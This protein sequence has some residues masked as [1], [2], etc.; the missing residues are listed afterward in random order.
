MAL[1]LL[2]PL[3]FAAL[4]LAVESEGYRDRFLRAAVAFGVAAWALV[5]LLSLPSAVTR[6]ALAV[7]WLLVAV[8]AFLRRRPINLPRLKPDP[9]VVVC[10]AGCVTV[11]V[12]TGLL[13]VL[14]PPNSTDAMAYHLPRVVY[15][16]EQSSVR[17]FPTP[18]LNQIMLQPMAEY[19][20]LHAYLLAGGDWFLNLVQWSSSIGAMVGVSLVARELGA[21]ARGQALAALVS[22]TI[23]AGILASS[24]AKNDYVLA[25]WL[26]AAV[27]FAARVGAARWKWDAVCL[28]CAFGLAL[29]TKATAYLFMPALVAVAWWAGARSGARAMPRVWRSTR[30]WRPPHPLVCPAITLAC[31]LAIDTPLFIRNYRLSRSPLGF[32]SAHGDGAFRWRNDRLGWKPLVSNALRNFSDQL[33]AR[34]QRWNQGVYGFVVA[35]HKKLRIDWNDPATTWP[36][37]VFAPPVNANHEAN[38]PNRWQ[39]L[40]LALA[41][42][43]AIRR[44]NALWLWYTAA[45]AFGFLAFCEY[46]KW[47]PFLARLFLPLLVASAPL[48]GAVFGRWRAPFAI[49]LSLFLLNNAR[50][51][52]FQNWVRPWS[53]P[54]SVLHADRDQEYFA[55]LGSWKNAPSYFSAV[56]LLGH[57]GCGVIGIDITNLTVEYPLQALL[58]ERNPGARF[59]HTGVTN[60]TRRYPPPVAAT[61][62]AVVC[63]DC[64]GD[65]KRLSLYAGFSKSTTIGR[66]VVFYGQGFAP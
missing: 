39:L 1:I 42:L 57:S 43:A 56:S 27:Y 36:W 29:D 34:S 46:L 23:P 50:P 24:G 14:S 26:V 63:L 11:A 49:L 38:A 12:F 4:F 61:P 22:A 53:G 52:L 55:D 16:A 48:M 51:V 44:H 31:A 13:A 7:A 5:E 18:Y 59:L 58:R 62:C 32:D 30:D 3:A 65:A 41:V 9:V 19:L 21:D 66:F 54:H 35:V 47:Q 33:G 17:F 28:G 64:I 2:L 60:V 40:L 8:A 37:A 10:L 25:M 6:W 45:L 15:W 20:M